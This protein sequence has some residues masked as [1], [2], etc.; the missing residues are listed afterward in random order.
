[1]C[2]SIGRSR[3]VN[4]HN[5]EEPSAGVWRKVPLFGKAHGKDESK[6]DEDY[7]YLEKSCLAK[8]LLL[9]G[10]GKDLGNFSASFAERG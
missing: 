2:R 3:K 4:R 1:M 9:R 10:A 6:G 5:A 7:R 8:P